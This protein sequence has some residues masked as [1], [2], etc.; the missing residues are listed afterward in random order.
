MLSGT[1]WRAHAPSA[2]GKPAQHPTLSTTGR[3]A[4]L[5]GVV[6]LRLSKL[7]FPWPPEELLLERFLTTILG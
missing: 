3:W 1:P 5:P 6:S 4:A 2:P 7:S